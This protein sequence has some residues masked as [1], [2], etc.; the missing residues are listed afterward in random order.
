MPRGGTSAGRAARIAARREEVR[1]GLLEAARQVFEE[2]GYH[3][4]RVSDITSRAGVSHGLF[5][6]YFDSKQDAF[7][8]LAETVDRSLV[9]SMDIYLR[10]YP[11]AELP[12]P[13]MIR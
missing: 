13:S 10:R 5:Y 2:L 6:N 3:P 8:E 12:E 4:A 9:D 7:R 11:N 1:Q